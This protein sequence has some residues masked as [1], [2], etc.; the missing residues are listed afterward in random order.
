MFQWDQLFGTFFRTPT[1]ARSIFRSSNSYDL[2]AY[3]R[4][5]DRFL[6]FVEKSR[7]EDLFPEELSEE[8]KLAFMD[9]TA[10]QE[11]YFCIHGNDYWNADVT[12]LC[13]ALRGE[14]YGTYDDE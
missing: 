10:S 14:L 2:C 4:H 5:I 9:L 3:P 1:R 13:F 8:E 12:S 6:V 7:P 11:G